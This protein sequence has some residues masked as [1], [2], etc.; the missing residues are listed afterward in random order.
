MRFLHPQD[1]ETENSD[2]VKRVASHAVKRDKGAELACHAIA[3][4]KDSVEEEGVHWREEEAGIFVA[5]AAAELLGDPAAR[6][7]RRQTVI[8]LAAAGT[9]AQAPKEV[10]D[11]PFLASNVYKA[12]GRKSRR[13]KS[14]KAACADNESKNE[15]ACGSKD[16]GSEHDSNSVG[17]V[18]RSQGEDEKVGYVGKDVG[19]DN[20]RHS[21]VDDA[22][23]VPGRVAKFAHHI[24]CLENHVR[25]N[26]QAPFSQLYLEGTG[27]AR[28]LR[29]PIRHKPRVQRTAQSP[30]LTDLKTSP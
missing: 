17:S 12:A 28:N 22:G 6:A 15:S 1:D 18:D 19:E 16:F 7:L 2:K 11:V 8:V 5:K 21:R 23:Q 4:G 3:T 9:E 25:I 27:F 24:I 29:Y 10:G 13:I 20:Q 30:S 14:A 26:I